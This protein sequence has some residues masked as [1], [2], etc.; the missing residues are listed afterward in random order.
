MDQDWHHAWVQQLPSSSPLTIQCLPPLWHIVHFLYFILFYFIKEPKS[1]S[2]A[3]L[4]YSS[5]EF[6]NSSFP[7]LVEG[8][9]VVHRAADDA[10]WENLS[11]KVR[12]IRFLVLLILQWLRRKVP[13]FYLSLGPLHFCSVQVIND[14]HV[15]LS[16]LLS[17]FLSG[18]IKNI[19]ALT[20]NDNNYFTANNGNDK[21]PQQWTHFRTIK[22]WTRRIRTNKVHDRCTSSARG[23]QSSWKVETLLFGAWI[24]AWS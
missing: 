19:G 5:T 24:H 14:K 10:F 3:A 7:Q 8:Q 9:S 15:L 1:N 17:A 21:G 16:H 12:P 20:I 13:F 23:Q 4:K 6:S 18:W 22:V 2:R 11:F